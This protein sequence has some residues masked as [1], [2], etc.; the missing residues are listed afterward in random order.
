[1]IVVILTMGKQRI[2]YRVCN[3][4][5]DALEQSS[6]LA[7]EFEQH[8]LTCIKL[9]SDYVICYELQPIGT[10]NILDDDDLTLANYFLNKVNSP[11][12]NNIAG[13]IDLACGGV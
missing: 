13:L 10:I 5:T 8:N 11:L 1:M 2:L 3:D 7:Q 9:I 4:I 12:L 6:V